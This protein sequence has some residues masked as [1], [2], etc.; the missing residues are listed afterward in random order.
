MRATIYPNDHPPAHVHIISS[1]AEAVFD[2]NC[3][4]GPPVLRNTFRFKRRELVRIVAALATTLKT[5][6]EKWD[7]IHGTHPR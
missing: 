7:R 1:D 4:T 2:L 6:C 5:L 3:P